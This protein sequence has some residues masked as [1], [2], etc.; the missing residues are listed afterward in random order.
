MRVHFTGIKGVGM[1]A[2]A[3]AYQ[4]RGWEVQGSDT[5]EVQITDEPLKKRTIQVC[6]RFTPRNISKIEK[7]RWIPIIDKLVYTGAHHGFHNVEVQW[8][9]SRGIPIQNYARAI[10]EFFSD[11]KQIAVCGVGGK[12]TTSAMIATVLKECGKYPSW[13]IGTSEIDS[14]P[15]AGH[16]DEKGEWAVIEADEYWADSAEDK[17]SKFMY[18]N[19][20]IIVCTNIF[21]DHPD[22]FPTM[23]EFVENYWEFFIA[24]IPNP[25]RRMNANKQII[26][27]KLLISNQVKGVL[28]EYIPN[29]EMELEKRR[30]KWI[31]FGNDQKEMAELA[32]VMKVPGEHNIRNG[33]AAIGAA[34]IMG[35][36]S[37]KAVEGL[38]QYKGAKRR[39]EYYGEFKGAKI[40]DDY[41]HHP[42]EIEAL[43]ETAR[44]FFPIKT[45]LRL[46][47]NPHTYSRTKA[48]FSDF[49]KVLSIAD[50][51]IM[52]PIFASAREKE[53][54]T[55]NSEMLSAEIN[56]QGGNSVYMKNGEKLVR[57]LAETAKKGEVIFTVGAG[58]IYKIITQII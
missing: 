17:K 42:H 53:D 16:W 32:K 18:L 1:A 54:P 4:D 45:R 25:S 24:N 20:E 23:K 12:T 41:A 10:G 48:F 30:I 46:I 39:F 5:G 3:L 29:W 47:F 22:A 40:Y 44:E 14:L 19:P 55:V 9:R 50:E 36:D 27:K 49:A 26:E 2:L 15:A 43:I 6:S 34:Q 56:R 37:Q 33:M 51:V 8:A 35:I 28:M 31:I 7:S 21:H 52:V 57:Y 13:L 38:S 58:D 11:K